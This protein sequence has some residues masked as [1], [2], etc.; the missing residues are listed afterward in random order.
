MHCNGK[1]VDFAI[2]RALNPE[3]IKNVTVVKDKVVLE[4]EYGEK[5]KNGVFLIT[6]K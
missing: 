2:M 1:E 4:K 6:L 5:G 3:R